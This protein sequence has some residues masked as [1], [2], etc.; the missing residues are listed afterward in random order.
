MDKYNGVLLAY[1]KIVL[2]VSP[3]LCM[4]YLDANRDEITSKQVMYHLAML[5]EMEPMF[6]YLSHE[7]YNVADVYDQ[8]IL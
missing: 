8:Y 2:D 3:P 4:H 5:D 6:S 1:H 7:N